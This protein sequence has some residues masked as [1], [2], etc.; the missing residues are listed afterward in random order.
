MNSIDK[1]ATLTHY[2]AQAAQATAGLQ[3]TIDLAF[4]PHL[5]PAPIIYRAR[6]GRRLSF[7]SQSDALSYEYG[8]RSWPDP[9]KAGTYNTAQSEGWMDARVEN[10]EALDQLSRDEASRD[11]YFERMELGA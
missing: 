2:K 10:L 8:Y 7:R 9:H 11:K 5:T 3:P 6:C 4:R 1:A